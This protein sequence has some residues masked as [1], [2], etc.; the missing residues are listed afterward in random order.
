MLTTDKM[1]I[2]TSSQNIKEIDAT[3]FKEVYI[4]GVLKHY[5]F[6]Q[7]IPYLLNL[8]VNL[9]KEELVIEW[10]S[11]ILRDKYFDFITKDT[12]K[13]CLNNINATNIINIDIDSVIRDSVVVKCDITFDILTDWDVKEYITFL[14]ASIKN[15]KKWRDKRYRNGNLVIENVVGN[16]K[17]HKRVSIYGKEKEM[18]LKSN[19]PF[20][21]T[22]SNPSL[23]K[24]L[25]KRRVRFELN[26]NTIYS[27]KKELQ[28]NDTSLVTVLN[29][30]ATPL[31]RLVNEIFDVNTDYNITEKN[32]YINLLILKDND[33]DIDKVRKRLQRFY[34]PLTKMSNVIRPIQLTKKKH[35]NTKCEI[36]NITFRFNT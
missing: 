30:T 35:E 9:E 29:S 11:K 1:K 36:Q 32:E 12:V 23:I 8:K 19:L 20:L 25:A 13:E 7:K 22:L 28:I 17:Y 27:I 21:N 31:E 4:N 3:K 15:S 14:Q 34:S 26:L 5:T 33:F 24:G 10:T 6:N 2:I 16:Q 18:N